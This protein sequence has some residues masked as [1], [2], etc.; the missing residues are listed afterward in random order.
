MHLAR[1][2]L[3]R[4]R[5]C[6]KRNICR[7]ARICLATVLTLAAFILLG[8]SLSSIIRAEKTPPS[9]SMMQST[10]VSLQV[11]NHWSQ[12]H[13]FRVS[14]SLKDPKFKQQTDAIQVD[15]NATKTI[16]VLLDPIDLRGDV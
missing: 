6:P 10:R 16:E 7:A 2:L 14:S 8:V 13:W 1:V 4:V 9:R 3:E 11:I 5:D 12:N 15:A